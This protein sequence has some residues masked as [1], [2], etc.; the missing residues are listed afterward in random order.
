MIVHDIPH[1]DLLNTALALLL[2]AIGLGCLLTRRAVIKQVIGLRIMV[3][4]VTLSLVHAAQLQGDTPIGEAMVISALVVEAIVIAVALA[5]IVNVYRHYPSGDID[6][7]S[8]LK[9]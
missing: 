1:L 6:D 2:F 7:L 3:Q 8:R 9:W 4:G 5:M